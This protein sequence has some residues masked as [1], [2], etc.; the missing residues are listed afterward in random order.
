[1]SSNDAPR[2]SAWEVASSRCQVRCV[3][4]S[5]SLPSSRARASSVSSSSLMPYPAVNS[6]PCGSRPRS[7]ANSR[8]TTRIITV[9]AAS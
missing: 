4:S 9:T 3:A 1:M 8:N 2:Y 7:S 6:R 5:V